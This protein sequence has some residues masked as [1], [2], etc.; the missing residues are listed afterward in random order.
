MTDGIVAIPIDDSGQ[1]DPRW[2]RAGKVAVGQVANASLLSWEGFPVHWDRLH[3]EGGEGM[4]HA[5][6]ARFLIDQRVTLVAANHMGPGMRHM[7]DRMGI[8][9]VLGAVGG[10]QEFIEDHLHEM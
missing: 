9:V 6:I 10:A 7:L 8:P 2:G 5:R 1:V 3:D 4:H